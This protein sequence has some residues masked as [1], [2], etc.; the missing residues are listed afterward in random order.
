MR[1]ATRWKISAGMGRVRYAHAA[2]LGGGSG[3]ELVAVGRRPGDNI[4]ELEAVYKAAKRGA[5]TMCDL[6]RVK[7]GMARDVGDRR[8]ADCREL[9]GADVGE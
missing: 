9:P 7:V 5:G 4:C 1:R 6:L 8:C 3:L 2:I